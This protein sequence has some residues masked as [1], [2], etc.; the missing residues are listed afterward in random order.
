M[1]PMGYQRSAIASKLRALHRA[2]TEAGRWRRLR[3]KVEA[4][5]ASPDEDPMLKVAAHWHRAD[6]LAHCA[7]GEARCAEKAARLRAEVQALRAEVRAEERQPCGARCRDGHACR[8]PRVAGTRRCKL[9]GG[10]STGPRTE[11]GR[12]RCREALAR[13]RTLRLL[14][15]EVGAEALPGDHEEEVLHA[16]RVERERAAPRW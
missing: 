6:T 14:S 12:A 5:V 11:E 2:T 4:D 13:V 1:A 7:R 9:H 3:A 16:A 15:D 10:K 8:A